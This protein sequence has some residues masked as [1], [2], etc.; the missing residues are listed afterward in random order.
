MAE[1]KKK[2]YGLV[3]ESKELQ[4]KAML[5]SRATGASKEVKT[6][7]AELQR[8]SA[9]GQVSLKGYKPADGDLAPSTSQPNNIMLNRDL[10]DTAGL[11]AQSVDASG[12][13]GLLSAAPI[14]VS[15]S[16]DGQ[17]YKH[18]GATASQGAIA[19]TERSPPF[20]KKK[21]EEKAETPDLSPLFSSIKA[22]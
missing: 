4:G 5:I 20:K 7:L 16:L 1:K 15:G 14:S 6:K 22:R 9:K 11:L 18:K 3:T 10:K 12:G 8:A 19:H 13:A 17:F 21:E 2:L